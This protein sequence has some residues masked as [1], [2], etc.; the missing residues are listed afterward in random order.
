MQPDLQTITSIGAAAAPFLIAG[1]AGLGWLYKHERERRASAEQ[2][3]SERKRQVYLALLSVYFDMMKGVKV[4]NP[5]DEKELAT[6]LFDASADLLLFGSDDV[7]R[8]FNRLRRR[9]LM[10]EMRLLDLGELMIV[11][12]KDMGHRRTRMSADEALSHFIN[13]YD[14]AFARRVLPHNAPDTST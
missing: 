12:R 5:L 10:N 4:S 7:S 2:Q 6:R 11:I 13:D 3:I 14:P 9:A 8:A 1:L